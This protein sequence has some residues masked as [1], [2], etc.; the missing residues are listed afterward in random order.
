MSQITP[1]ALRH[2]LHQTPELMFE[3]FETTRLL[4]DAVNSIQ[5]LIVHR[6]LETGLVVE[7]KVNEGDYLLFRADI[8]ALPIK[9]DTGVSFAS[10]SD[11]MHACG[12]DVHSSVLYGFIQKVVREKI[13]QNIVFLFQPGEEGVTGH[14]AKLKTESRKLKWG[15]DWGRSVFRRAAGL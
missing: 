4:L 9:E 14:K 3:E 10:Q 2:A 12:H 13:K 7:Y 5:G 15:G 6:P 8:D 11:N 1:I